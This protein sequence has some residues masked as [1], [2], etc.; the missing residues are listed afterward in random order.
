VN[1][2]M[3]ARRLRQY[4]YNCI[5]LKLERNRVIVQYRSTLILVALCIASL[6][7]TWPASAQTDNKELRWIQRVILGPEY[8]GSGEICSRWVRTPTLSVF[9]GDESREEI[10]QE[11]VVHLNETLGRTPIK[12]I[13]LLYP[14]NTRADISL[15]F[16]PVSEF[17][18]IA[19]HHNFRYTK[20]NQGYFWTWW[21]GRNEIYRGVILLSS[22]L[23]DRNRIRHYALEEITQVLGL[24]NDSPEYPESIFYSYYSDGGNAQS[25]SGRDRQLIHFFYNSISPGATRADVN[26]AY[27]RYWSGR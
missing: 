16:A 9:G 5:R 24:S 18:E 19:A 11:V 13:M 6:M 2:F 21:N 1:G 27:Q 15:Y 26:S 4:G 23:L 3:L 17:P 20:G 22:D 8:G 10:V 7:V 25:L 14:E 12:R